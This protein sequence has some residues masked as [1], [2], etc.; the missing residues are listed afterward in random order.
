MQDIVQ[1]LI[2]YRAG[3]EVEPAQRHRYRNLASLLEEHLGDGTDSPAEVERVLTEQMADNPRI[4]DLLKRLGYQPATN[5]GPRVSQQANVTG[6]GATIVQIGGNAQGLNI[7]PRGRAAAETENALPRLQTNIFISYRRATSQ[8]FADKVYGYLQEQV[9]GT[10]FYD[11]QTMHTGVFSDTLRRAVE[12]CDVFLSVIS[13]GTFARTH[14]PD[15]WVRREIEIALQHQK[16][17]IPVLDETAT[18]PKAD[19]LPVTIRPLV[20]LHGVQIYVQYFEAGIAYLLDLIR[21][22]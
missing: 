13:A 12:A 8:Y 16:R 17:I 20:S 11:R 10:V 21:K 4:R 2:D 9:A 19:D 3:R 22:G 5:T 18:F 7:Q 15:D 14:E 1:K 6:S